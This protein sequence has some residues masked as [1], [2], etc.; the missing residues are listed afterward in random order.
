MK[1]LM[2]KH[3]IIR[4]KQEGNSNRK[5]A[6]LLGMNRKTV[7]RYWNDFRDQIN[8]ITED[9]A[10]IS[11]VQEQIANK[12][13]YDTSNRRKYKYTKE[14]DEYLNK[15]LE[16]EKT[17]DSLL[18]SHKQKL[19]NKQI[20]KAIKSA[21]FEIGISTISNQIKI[22]R[23]KAK[24]C[25]IKQQYD[26][27]DRLEYDFGEVKLVI[28]GKTQVYH[29]A[30]LSSPAS[31]FRW[32]YLYKN[33]KQ[34][35]FMDSH[36]RFF[37]K[38]EGVFK[39]VVYD[40]MKNVVTK[41]IGKNE[42]ELNSNLLLLANYYGYQIN[43][44]NCFKGNEKGHVEG[45]VKIIRNTVFAEKYVFLTYEDACSYLENTLIEMSKDSQIKEEQNH[46]LQTKPPLELGK[47]TEQKVNTYSFV[48]LNRNSY[49]VPDYLVGKIVT[50][51]AYVDVV[52]IYSNNHLVCEHKKKDGVNEISI[53]INH[54]LNS[55]TKKP[56]A[57]RNSL[58]LKSQPQ[59]KSIFDTHFTGNPKKFIDILIKNKEKPVEA[60]LL[61]ITSYLQFQGEKLPVDYAAPS[62]G[63]L[64][65]KTRSLITSY[66]KLLIGGLD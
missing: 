56:G 39:E 15:I 32:A 43:V 14:I 11:F 22:K 3:A 55:L 8:A 2:D 42:K 31:N 48:Q 65:S 52:K 50:V 53:D 20:F 30:V 66:N 62:P 1:K 29:M 27:G 34:D 10:D 24:E 19:T 58:V 54:Y 45:S 17:K 64:E 23:D 38:M 28:D 61:E 26:F 9:D 57:L 35:V 51:R 49:S 59:L 41:F 16:K 18:G 12:P 44:T 25:F 46:L 40:N 33:Q 63:K 21:G 37:N 6:E 36:V 47:I 5:V 13:S 4:L 60:L 7:S